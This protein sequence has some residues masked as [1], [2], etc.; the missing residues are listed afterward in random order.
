MANQKPSLA[1]R[2]LVRLVEGWPSYAHGESISGNLS[3]AGFDVINQ[4]NFSSVIDGMP[5]QVIKVFNLAD[6]GYQHLLSY[7]AAV[8]S[9]NLAKTF[10]FTKSGKYGIVELEKL[11]H[12]VK[13][14]VSISEYIDRCKS[15][16]KR[17]KHRWGDAFKDLILD[18]NCSIEG[19]NQVN[20]SKLA[21]DCHED[22][23]MFRGTTPVLVD[24]LYGENQALI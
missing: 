24:V 6:I 10:S 20:A 1:V 19:H 14:A 11:D 2:A 9:C 18:I 13:E 23:I 15:N 3:L 8:A 16:P 5:G 22:N 17:I 4:G 21:W 7:S 12:K